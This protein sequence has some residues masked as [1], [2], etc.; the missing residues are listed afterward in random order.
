MGHAA[1]FVDRHLARITTGGGFIPEIDGLRFLAI[2]PVV[3][4]HL[5]IYVV[6]KS[7]LTFHAAPATSLMQDV[8]RQGRYGVDLFFVLSGFIL[9]LPF[10]RASRK[11]G[12]S[13]DLKRYYL[14]RLTRIEPP[15]VASML[16]FFAMLGVTRGAA[17]ARA[18]LPNLGASLLYLHTP[19]FG[20]SSLINSVA[21][22]LE[23][24]VQFYL[25]VPLLAMVFRLPSRRRR[26]GLI[27]VAALFSAGRPFWW[28]DMPL[29]LPAFLQYFLVGFLLA[30]LYLARH[31]WAGASPSWT[32][33]LATLGAA[34]CWYLLHRAHPGLADA[35]LPA[36]LAV[37][38][39]GAFRGRLL[40]ALCRNLFV[41]TTGG[42]CYSIYLLH[43][44]VIS[45]LGRHTVGLGRTSV[46]PLFFAVQSCLVVVP[47][48]LLSAVFY[49]LIERPCMVPDWPA[50][51]ARRVRATRVRGRR[52]G[53]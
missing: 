45:F 19:V 27:A 35:L 40:N 36:V 7:G 15:Y 11:R 8:I 16:F 52:A 6:E 22:S 14:R 38:V 50:R 23:V 17:E 53:D 24:E 4:H 2:L 1:T 31:G 41:R 46:Y 9:A 51:V 34:V 44:P 42:M 39:R 43:Y 28:P 47:V 13:V 21:W 10:A 49:M 20:T 37:V 12:R 48:L 18:L 26:A 30:D 32:A 29:V 33:D 3:L 5:Q 25:V